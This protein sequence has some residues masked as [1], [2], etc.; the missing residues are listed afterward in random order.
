MDETLK[1]WSDPNYQHTLSRQDLTLAGEPAVKVEMVQ[2][3]PGYYP[4]GTMQYMDVI[5]MSSDRSLVI[6]TL[7]PPDS[8]TDYSQ[9][10]SIVDQ[11]AASLA[12]TG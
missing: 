3:G 5:H 2:T 7:L 6:F 8:T 11:A 12:L 10:K 4:K 9:A 1:S